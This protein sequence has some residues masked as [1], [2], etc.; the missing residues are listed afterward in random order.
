MKKLITA[1]LLFTALLVPYLMA[2]TAEK[3]IMG[4]MELD[5]CHIPNYKQE[6]LCG[7]HSVFE[8]RVAAKGRKIDIQ[9]AIIPSVT[10]AKETDPLVFFA[11]GPG[12][13][14]KSMARFVTMSFKEIHENRDV[15]L[16][17]QRGMGSSAPLSCKQP[18]DKFLSLSDE[19]ASQ[20]MREILQQC[21]IDLNTDVTKYTQDLANQDIHEI[22]LALGYSK[23]NL[24]GVS[25]GTRSALLYANQFPEQVRTVIMDGVAPLENKVPLYAN[26]DAERALQTLFKDCN[27][28]THCLATFPTLEQDFNNILTAFGENGYEVT[29]NDPNTDEAISFT[30]TRNTFVNAI[31]TLLY[32]PDFSR[33]LPIIIQQAKVKDFKALA[34]IMTA[35]GDGDMAMGA[36]M[37][38]LCSEDYARMSDQ[39]IAIETNKGFVG[40]AFINIFKNACSVWPKAPLPKLYQ[41]K[42]SSNAP[43]LIL[44]GAIDPVTPERW[45]EKMT[46]VMTNSIH[47][48]AANTGHNVA[49]KGCAPK[50]IAQLVNQGNLDNID[51]SC[52]DKLTRP[53]F[54]INAS[55]PASEVGLLTDNSKIEHL[56][57][58]DLSTDGL[59]T[60][61]LSTDA[62]EKKND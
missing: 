55:G 43:T 34:T 14:A 47:L 28:D 8:D 32:V 46:E 49:P 22:L 50:L 29:M 44:S 62:L 41:Q 17:D 12:Q 19:E 48:V 52:L 15:I 24:Y 5:Y 58:D 59:S 53:T 18:E 10:E 11:G 60:D 25:W 36:Q 31:R 4:E 3:V 26:A 20:L 42:L 38:I 61:S 39:A 37:T 1:A 45:G 27:A 57:T 54:F 35:F 33:L 6:V 40:D 2:A 16:I 21:L 23:V 51:G 7:Q 13:G 9:F 56:P 30:M